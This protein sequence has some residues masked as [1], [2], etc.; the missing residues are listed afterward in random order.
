[1]LLIVY[2]DMKIWSYNAIIIIH[3]YIKQYL[4]Y[5]VLMVYKLH[6]LIAF[7]ETSNVYVDF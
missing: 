5:T 3:F 4:T 7:I 6:V 1:M 2:I